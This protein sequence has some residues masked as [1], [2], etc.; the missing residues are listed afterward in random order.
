MNSL[1]LDTAPI[2]NRLALV[3]ILFMVI[4]HT[5]GVV[6]LQVDSLQATFESVSWLNLLLS[7]VLVGGFQRPFNKRFFLF[8]LLAFSLGMLAEVL[9]VNTG[10]PFG[11]YYYTEKFGWQILGVPLIIGLNWALLSY[12]CGLLIQDYFKADLWK[13]LSAS[14]LMLLIDLLLEPFAIRHRF[15]VWQSVTPPLQNYLSWFVVSLPIQYG[16]LKL[17]P[18]SKNQI[19]LPYL[20]ILVLFLLADLIA[21]HLLA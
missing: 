7:F 19:A 4:N 20:L 13:V 3:I 8:A 16:F 14:A 15:W 6:G 2:L 9:G 21:A 11:S 18:T 12:C 1:Q 5:I 17:L 10:F